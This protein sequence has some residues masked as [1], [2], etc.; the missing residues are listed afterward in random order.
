MFLLLKSINQV[1][2]KQK[3]GSNQT[4]DV[5]NV[6]QEQDVTGK[7]PG[8]KAEKSRVNTPQDASLFR[9][10]VPSE[11]SSSSEEEMGRGGGT[12]LSLRVQV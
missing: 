8:Q 10:L 5:V 6:L 12:A 7:I 11:P 3:W 2:L 1:A 9:S 4:R